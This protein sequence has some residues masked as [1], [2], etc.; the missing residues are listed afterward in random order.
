[1]NI[2]N[3]RIAKAFEDLQQFNYRFQHT[4]GSS[5]CLA[6]A[7][8]RAPVNEFF[9][10]GDDMDEGTINNVF[11]STANHDTTEEYDTLEDLDIHTLKECIA[12]DNDYQQIIQAIKSDCQPKNLPDNDPATRHMSLMDPSAHSP[13]LIDG[14][15]IIVPENFGRNQVTALHEA[16]HATIPQMER[17]MN[18]QVCPTKINDIQETFGS[19]DK[20]ISEQP[21]LHDGKDRGDKITLTSIQPMNILHLDILQFSCKY[22]LS[23]RDHYSKYTWMSQ[24][25]RPDSRHVLQELDLLQNTFGW[26]TKIVSDNGSQLISEQIASYCKARNILHKTSSV[27]MPSSNSIAE[28]GVKKCK[29]ALRRSNGNFK[30]AQDILQKLQ[31]QIKLSDFNSSSL[32][33]FLKRQLKSPDM[34]SPNNICNNKSSKWEWSSGIA[35]REQARLDH[36]RIRVHHQRTLT[37]LPIGETVILQNPLSSKWGLDK[38]TVHEK[39]PHRDSY[40]L[41]SETGALL[42]RHQKFIRKWIKPVDIIRNKWNMKRSPSYAQGSD[43]MVPVNS[44]RLLQQTNSDQLE[45]GGSDKT[46]PLRVPVRPLTRLS[47]KRANEGT[48]PNLT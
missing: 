3:Q 46:Q 12:S 10:E 32:E 5:N 41:K 25:P 20:S 15:K 19:C 24:L 36:I 6:D 11:V 13:I 34:L 39:V 30:L 23:C 48:G 1:M 40:I 9:E 42:R 44:N 8:S 35:L 18:S 16:T 31:A 33:L 47:A 4:P 43:I 2:K 14:T 37:D 17:L 22:Y 27:H 28:L 38:F 7:L 45:T 29:F 26:T 21:S